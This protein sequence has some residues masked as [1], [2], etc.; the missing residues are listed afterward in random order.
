MKSKRFVLLNPE[1]QESE[2]M[3]LVL[4]EKKEE[5]KTSWSLRGVFAQRRIWSEINN[6]PTIPRRQHSPCSYCGGHMVEVDT[7]EEEVVKWKRCGSCG[8]HQEGEMK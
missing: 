1:E 5:E 4:V 6:R 3:E 7:T 8:R 2:S